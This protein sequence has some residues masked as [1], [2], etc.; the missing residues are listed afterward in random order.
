MVSDSNPFLGQK[1]ADIS[2][3][4]SKKYNVGLIA[5]R[6]KDWNNADT[7]DTD[8]L[9]NSPNSIGE[10]N[11]G[12]ELVVSSELVDDLEEEKPI[13]APKSNTELFLAKITSSTVSDHILH[14]GDVV[15]CVAN[16]DEIEK[17]RGNRDFF[18]VSTVGH[19][20]KPL[21]LWNSIAVVIF[22][23]MMVLVATERIAM[24]PAA[25]TVTCVYFIG[26]WI[27]FDEIPKLVNIRLLM[28]LGCSLSYAKAVTKTGLA[29]KIAESI[30]SSDPTPFEGILFIYAITLV[31][32][33]L[34]SNNAAAA[35]MY[36]ISV[37]L[38]DE[39][40]VINIL[41]CLN[42]VLTG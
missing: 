37:A 17:L 32:T 28:L 27:K 20:P 9:P 33:E 14:Y 38:A 15:L 23:A 34:I 21:D 8:D 26:G 39:L 24:C 36:P 2:S 16:S 10:T 30:S 40:E 29:L 18:V 7:N 5:V 4:F 42:S 3:L 19:L 13:E 12:V 6:S 25:L 31:I 11:D 22:I 35:L 1:L 41:C